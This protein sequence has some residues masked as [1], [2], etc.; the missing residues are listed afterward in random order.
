MRWRPLFSDNIQ[1]QAALTEEIH[2]SMD[3]I[4]DDMNTVS[5]SAQKQSVSLENLI[6]IIKHTL[7]HN[8]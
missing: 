7:R 1:R 4:C 2:A 8:E 6:G 5:S 3:G